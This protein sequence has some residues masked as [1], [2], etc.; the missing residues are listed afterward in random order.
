MSASSLSAPEPHCEIVDLGWLEER[1]AAWDRRVQDAATSNPFYAPRILMAHAA[2]G[3]A[4]RNLRFV[5]VRRGETL[6]SAGRMAVGLAHEIRNPLGAI[7]GAVQL[8]A[9]ELAG[10]PRLAVRGP[11]PAVL[12]WLTGRSDGAGLSTESGAPLPPLPGWG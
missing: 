2:H 10:E 11:A 1:R 12:A 4:P 3:L 6:A 8:L 5:V 7:R 9:R